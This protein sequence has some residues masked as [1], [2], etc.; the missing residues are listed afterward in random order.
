[1]HI[2]KVNQFCWIYST[3]RRFTALSTHF[4]THELTSQGWNELAKC[5]PLSGQD[6]YCRNHLHKSSRMLSQFTDDRLD[7]QQHRH[8]YGRRTTKG[9]CANGMQRDRIPKTFLGNLLLAGV[10]IALHDLHFF[11]NFNSEF[12]KCRNCYFYQYNFICI[13]R[14]LNWN[15]QYP[16]VLIFLALQISS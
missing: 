14:K 5:C 11:V 3:S 6:N 2:Y 9:R 1:M 16:I 8:H 12:E 10:L 4:Q 13:C 15:H 7:C